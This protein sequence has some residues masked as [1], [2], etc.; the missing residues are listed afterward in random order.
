MLG[1]GSFT[2]MLLRVTVL[3]K[4]WT[5]CD[6][7]PKERVQYEKKGTRG[8]RSL[9]HGTKASLSCTIQKRGGLIMNWAKERVKSV[10][11]YPSDPDEEFI[12]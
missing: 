1:S 4:R 12:L 9:S 11:I 10:I 3:E 8:T 5:L 7:K 2:Q 6:A